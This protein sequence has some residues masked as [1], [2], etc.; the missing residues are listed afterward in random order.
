MRLEP[1]LKR[2]VTFL[3]VYAALYC[4]IYLA[5]AGNTSYATL[6]TV[7]AAQFGGLYFLL[8]GNLKVAVVSQ[9]LLFALAA[10]LPNEL[11]AEFVAGVNVLIVGSMICQL[12]FIEL[13]LRR[14]KF[15]WD[16][17][18]ILWNC[19]VST[20]LVSNPAANPVGHNS[21]ALSFIFSFLVAL[22]ACV[23]LS[24]LSLIPATRRIFERL[25]PLRAEGERDSI[26]FYLGIG[27][28][29]TSVFGFVAISLYAFD[30]V[31][32]IIEAKDQQA[33]QALASVD[34]SSTHG[35][36]RVSA[37]GRFLAS[38]ADPSSPE[39]WPEEL[40][41][42]VP[43]IMP[44]LS[45][46]R[47]GNQLVDSVQIFPPGDSVVDERDL[48]LVS[49]ARWHTMGAS[50][51]M[52]EYLI[53]G[54]E[55]VMRTPE[56]RFGRA[57]FTSTLGYFPEG[58]GISTRVSDA[59]SGM[60]RWSSPRLAE[61]DHERY[62]S[63]EKVRDRD[64]GRPII[65][66]VARHPDTGMV[67]GR[68][69]SFASNFRSEAFVSFHREVSAV[70]QLILNTFAWFWLAI[71]L[72]VAGSVI[73]S[74]FVARRREERLQKIE[75]WFVHSE[76]PLSLEPSA[77]SEVNQLAKFF[78][79]I[80]RRYIRNLAQN[81]ELTQRLYAEHAELRSIVEAP[82]EHFAI[83]TASEDGKVLLANES[84]LSLTGFEVGASLF[85][86][87]R[88]GESAPELAAKVR[89]A[90][91][92]VR[93]T[94]EPV[95]EAVNIGTEGG[96]D[97]LHYLVHVSPYPSVD[98]ASGNSESRFMIWIN[99]IDDLVEARGRAE[100][101]AR[102]A[103]LGETVTG[104]AHEINQPLNTIALSTHNAMDMLGK[105]EPDVPRIR[106]KLER[107]SAQVQR[108]SKLIKMMKS[109]GKLA[110]DRLEDVSVVD[111][112]DEVVDML[113]PQL[114]LDGVRL[115]A[116]CEVGLRAKAST[117]LLQQVL[118]YIVIN[119]RDAITSNPDR[120]AEE[121]VRIRSYRDGD[122]VRIAISN[123]GPEIPPDVM[124]KIFNP[125]FTTKSRVEESGVGL[126]LSVC[127]QM[128]ADVGGKI[129]VESIQ[130]VTTFWLEFDASRSQDA[131]A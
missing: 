65:V 87:G 36:R 53:F 80:S 92:T 131:A 107:I 14:T 85:L 129:S 60:I 78:E 1:R 73:A 5:V 30:A 25:G 81:R 89:N 101:R 59:D 4:A 11:D 122:K 31:E 18:A 9:V 22:Q 28:S 84:A 119:A 57:F 62:F 13:I 39:S 64:T 15:K 115:D 52:D 34:R 102:L 47:I 44:T 63:F 130:G 94:G 72:F 88:T 98:I 26:H 10:I 46:I 82:A 127:N 77:L 116:E 103:M 2:Y 12:V 124:D 106:R 37:I 55:F 56:Y 38:T 42:E 20:L 45:S 27:V 120:T 3:G 99:N 35:I 23:L 70:N 33:S 91:E 121:S 95:D 71:V 109:H 104:M 114:S 41:S 74:R 68:D 113:S 86:R 7:L 51:Q 49:D 93:T 111:S 79:R 96:T 126:G 128:M 58:E 90:F 21:D 110:T 108:A 76:G 61:L 43:R 40:L 117:L 29:I 24:T 8:Y 48:H 75:D 97:R 50:T 32:A 112:V 105:D 69:M 19:V 16:Y 67:V 125:F 54:D 100:H 6:L 83:L 66:E 118:G 17:A 123:D